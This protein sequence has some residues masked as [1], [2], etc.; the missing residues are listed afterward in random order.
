[1]EHYA[2]GSLE[3]RSHPWL[4]QRCK[5]LS[6]HTSPQNFEEKPRPLPPGGDEFLALEVKGQT[7]PR[8]ELK[9]KKR[10]P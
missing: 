6:F 3:S 5:P 4:P 1:M 2:A 10:T 7:I 8:H 9:P